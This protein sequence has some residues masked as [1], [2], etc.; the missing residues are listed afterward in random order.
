MMPVGCHSLIHSIDRVG[1]WISEYTRASRTRR[2]ISCVNWEPKSRIRI[3]LATT[4]SALP[5]RPVEGD[6]LDM[7]RF[8][9]EKRRRRSPEKPATSL[10]RID[11]D[12]VAAAA[13]LSLMRAPVD[14][15]AV[16]LHGPGLYIPDV[17]H[18]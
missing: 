4:P 17:V 12:G 3:R 13:T 5:F 10:T 1:G 16:R 14:D 2:A 9:I 6:E 7:I 18:Q 11:D 8:E 15:E